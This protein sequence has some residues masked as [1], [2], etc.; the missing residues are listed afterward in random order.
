MTDEQVPPGSVVITPET[1]YR[2][3]HERYGRI[4]AAL[5]GI[6]TELHPLPAQLAEHDAYIN[7]L[8]QAGLP[9]RFSVVEADVQVLKGRWMWAV[10]AATAAAFLAGILGSLLPKAF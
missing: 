3:S 1:M 5:T 8:R 4:E 6:R 2:E 9:E 10:G 7:S